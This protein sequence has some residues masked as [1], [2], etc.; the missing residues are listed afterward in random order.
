[1]LSGPGLAFFFVF[2][3]AHLSSSKLNGSSREVATSDFLVLHLVGGID[4][5]EESESEVEVDT[6]VAALSLVLVKDA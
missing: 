2:F 3:I 5:D 1:M 6:N 4:E